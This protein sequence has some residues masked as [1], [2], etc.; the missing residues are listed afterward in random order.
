MNIQHKLHK[1]YQNV[2]FILFYFATGH[3]GSGKTMLGVEAAK[4]IDGQISRPDER[5][6][7]LCAY[8]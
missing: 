5:S 8:F 3:F 7:S 6:R 1:I 2:Y 4:N